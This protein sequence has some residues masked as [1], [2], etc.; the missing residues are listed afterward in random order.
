MLSGVGIICFAASYAVAM[1]L[2][3]SRLLFRSGVRGAV[4]L[5]FA[6][7]GLVAHTAYLYYE[8]VNATGAPLSSIR[9]WF[10][11]AAWVLV[12]V[13]LY[14]IYYHPHTAFGLFLLP[15]ALGLIGV[16][17]YLAK[18][19]P[20]AREPASQVWGGIHFASIVAAA[21]S[22]LVGFSAG[23]M[24]LWQ[25]RR[26]KR[27]MP[28]GRGLRLPS[29]EWLQRANSRAIVVSVLTLTMGVLS[30]VILNLINTDNPKGRLPWND[31]VVL[32]TVLM[33]AWL[34]AAVVF[35][36]VY[37]PLRSGRKVAYLTV[38]GF[39]FLLF[40]LAVMLFLNTQHGGLGR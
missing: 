21:V 29:L 40:A 3:I 9:D 20:F 13:Y 12:V 17:T 38:A 1:A 19:E 24:Y 37:K 23:V 15:L 4:M 11:V 22:V 5:A 35:A 26:L 14:L 36:R 16:G 34:L 28:V 18:G 8:A 7:A 2:E 30:G 25:A 27:K 33:L 39:V 6:G 32:S 10:L 31:P